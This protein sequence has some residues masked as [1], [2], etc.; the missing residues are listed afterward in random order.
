MRPLTSTDVSAPGA[1]SPIR[2]HVPGRRLVAPARGDRGVPGP[3]VWLPDLPGVSPC[4]RVVGAVYQ[5]DRRAAGVHGRRWSPGVG[6][7]RSRVARRVSRLVAIGRPAVTRLRPAMAGHRVQGDLLLLPRRLLQGDVPHATHLRCPRHITLVSRR[8]DPPAVSESS[9]LRAVWWAVPA[10]G[11]V[12][13]SRGRLLPS[14]AVRHRRRN[15]G[16][17]DQRGLAFE[18]DARLSLLAASDWRATRLLFLRGRQVHAPP[19]VA[20]LD[21]A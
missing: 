13:G 21:V 14:R 9:P 5:P 4:L 2:R 7:G 10:R 11:A 19:G 12:V 18:L 3:A 1:A 15:G 20:R 16:D 8:N 6:T 17:G